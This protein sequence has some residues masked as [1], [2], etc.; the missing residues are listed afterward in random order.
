MQYMDA[1]GAVMAA[2]RQGDD[3]AFRLL[4]ARHA[5]ALLRLAHRVTGNAHDAED[6]VQETF[7]R[8]YRE[9]E[10]FEE[11]ANPGTWL[12]RIAMNC[13]IDVL[14]SRRRDRRAAGRGEERPAPS[15]AGSPHQS[16]LS[17]E[18]GREIEAALDTLTD[19][20]RAAFVLR[21]FEGLS[22]DEI[23]RILNLG[24]SATK[25]SIFRAVRKMRVRLE[26]LVEG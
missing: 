7:L 17:R 5:R 18:I 4:V 12:Y 22:I 2:I 25:H 6:V 3:Q 16:L 15:R 19:L 26:P 1:D 11:R 10:R 8:A 23:G 21:H 24:T 14:R 13:A 9:L 20:E